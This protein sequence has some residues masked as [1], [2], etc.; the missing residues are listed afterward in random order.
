MNRYLIYFQLLLALAA[1]QTGWAESR[2]EEETADR[3]RFQ[4]VHFMTLRNL[5]G[6]RTPDERFGDERDRLRHGRCV[7]SHTPSSLLR[8]PDMFSRNGFVF[9]PES[10]IGL[11]A[12]TQAPAEEFW[13]DYATALDGQ[14]PLLY[15]HGYN[16]SFAKACEQASHFQANLHTP[17]RVLLFSWP[18]DGAILNYARDEADLFWS[19]AHLEKTLKSMIAQFGAGEFDVIGHSLGARGLLYALVLLAHENHDQL[20]LIN[21]VILTAPDIDAGVFKQ[22][23]PYLRPLAGNITL[24]VSDNDRPLALSREVHGYPRL[25]EAGP[26]LDD[27]EGV[28]I[29]DV[30]DIGGRSFSGHLYHLYQDRV[31]GDLNQLLNQGVYADQRAGLVPQAD[32]RWR[33]APPDSDR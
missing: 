21:Q 25:G 30:S 9:L 7:L 31:C 4:A 14:R 22:Y 8:M 23:L 29:I 12:V 32:S 27:I 2:G 20:P 6:D 15:L 28:Q 16:T 10:K 33:L 26:H 13:A 24:Y 11:E 19:V 5:T 3:T 17:D 18:S 1:T